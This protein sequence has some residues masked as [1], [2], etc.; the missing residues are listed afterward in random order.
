MWA[1]G[2]AHAGQ[3]GQ[4][5]EVGSLR[6]EGGGGGGGGRQD[7]GHGVARHFTPHHMALTMS[8][9]NREEGPV[10]DREEGPVTTEGGRGL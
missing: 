7:Q 10:A 2:G 8:M 1:Q 4:A 9:T 6:R 5:V 3:E